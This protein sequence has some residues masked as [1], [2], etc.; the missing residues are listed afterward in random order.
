MRTLDR[1]DAVDLYQ[2][3]LSYQ[4]RQ[5]FAL[6]RTGGLLSQCVMLQKYAPGA[7]IIDNGGRHW[8]MCDPGY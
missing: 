7:L 5:C 8:V 2:S 6:G 4:I 3:Q 1:R